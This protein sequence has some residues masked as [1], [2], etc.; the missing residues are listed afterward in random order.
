MDGQPELP[1]FGVAIAVVV[2][3]LAFFLRTQPSKKE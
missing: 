2:A 3:A 1:G